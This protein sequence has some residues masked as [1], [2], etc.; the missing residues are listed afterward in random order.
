[1]FTS[2]YLGPRVY[3][4]VF[5][6][7][8]DSRLA[9]AGGL[10][11]AETDVDERSPRSPRTPPIR[12]LLEAFGDPLLEFSSG[13][14]TELLNNDASKR[15]QEPVVL[16]RFECRLLEADVQAGRRGAIKELA[17]YNVIR[18]HAHGND[19]LSVLRINVCSGDVEAVKRHCSL[20]EFGVRRGWRL[21]RINGRR[22]SAARFQ[23]QSWQ[24]EGGADL[25]F[26]PLVPDLRIEQNG[27]VRSVRPGSG[28]DMLGVQQWW[29][30]Q[31]INGVGFQ[32]RRFKFYNTLDAKLVFSSP[33]YANFVCGRLSCVPPGVER[34]GRVTDIAATLVRKDEATPDAA[35]RKAVRAYAT[36]NAAEYKRCGAP[37]GLAWAK[38][39]RRDLHPTRRFRFDDAAIQKKEADLQKFEEARARLGHKSYQ[40]KLQSNREIDYQIRV[41]ENRIATLKRQ[42]K[43]NAAKC[44]TNQAAA[45]LATAQGKEKQA[46]AKMKRVAACSVRSRRRAQRVGAPRKLDT[47]GA[48]E[49][50]D[51]YKDIEWYT[52]G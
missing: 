34:L 50:D 27:D 49:S 51:E 41:M 1:M 18:M 17:V 44:A 22:F 35:E 20:A 46:E 23:P 26:V 15:K 45:I 4:C 52:V 28:A 40:K 24:K 36:H 14:E 8:R 43:I 29:K 33:R 42:K 25:I 10:S 11:A 12:P 13:A 31:S 6:F 39:I 9:M 3:L 47:G 48:S 19:L 16:D 32:W 21:A 2:V 38:K 5:L 30:L 37:F 7:A